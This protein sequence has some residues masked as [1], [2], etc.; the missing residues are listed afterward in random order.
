MSLMK[1]Q[2]RWEGTT[3][4]QAAWT[5]AI[6]MTVYRW[7]TTSSLRSRHRR[8][9]STSGSLKLLSDNTAPLIDSTSSRVTAR[10]ACPTSPI[11]SQTSDRPKLQR[12]RLRRPANRCSLAAV[13]REVSPARSTSTCTLLFTASQPLRRGPVSCR[14]RSMPVPEPKKNGRVRCVER[15]LLTHL[16]TRTTYARTRTNVRLFVMSVRSVS[17]NVIIS[18]STRCSSTRENS[19]KCV[20]VVVSASKTRRRSGRTNAS[21]QMRVLTPVNAVA[22]LSRLASVCGTTTTEVRHVV[23]LDALLREQQSY[24]QRV[25][26]FCSPETRWRVWVT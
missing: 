3:G 1:A 12:R 6:T 13:V 11:R 8:L 4:G 16:T 23:D 14:W 25:R 10:S 17:K 20:D 7:Q 5:R 21:T 24:Q 9:S 26:L 15:F 2:Y 22:K 18:K 19:M